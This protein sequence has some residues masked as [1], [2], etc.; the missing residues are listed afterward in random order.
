MRDYILALINQYTRVGEAYALSY[1]NQVDYV[2][3]IPFLINDGLVYIA[4]SIKRYPASTELAPDSGEDYG[5]WVRHILPEDYM[6]MRPGGLRVLEAPE[7][8]EWGRYKE[9]MQDYRL[10]EPDYI[11]IPKKFTG[12]C[13]LEYFRRPQLLPASP[14]DT[15]GV[16]APLDVQ[17]ALCYYAASHLVLYDDAFAYASLYNEFENHVARLR[18][19]VTT[20]IRTVTDAYATD[21]DTDYL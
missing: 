13:L 12:T 6:F 9:Y 20:E 5:K 3:R 19:N 18:E 7:H 16:D 17:M 21:I 2:N 11:L 1:N 14:A 15:A 4:S 10:V 8:S